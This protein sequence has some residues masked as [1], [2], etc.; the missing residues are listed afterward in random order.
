MALSVEATGWLLLAGGVAGVLGTAGGITSLVSYPALLAVG[1][2]ALPANVSNLV[3][4]VACWP[5]AALSSRRELIGH[6]RWL[7]RALPVAAI[8]AA[9]GAAALL[10]TPP[11][12]FARVVPV[13]VLAGSVALLAQPRL[14]R[15]SGQHGRETGP[16]LL[17]TLGGVSVYGGYFGAG[18]GVMLL[19]A[20]AVLLDPRLPRA[21]AVKNMLVGA[22]AVA[23]AVVLVL[24][25]PVDW[26]AVVPLAIG[27]FVGS[28]LGPVVAR[29]V[30]E[31]VVRWGVA[32]L[33]L[34]LAVQ[35]WL[36]PG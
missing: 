36:H 33:G 22:S 11:G 18:S 17:A 3:A 10:F 15:V 14:A 35:L 27:L 8:A 28:T 29:R 16:L 2:P 1:V 34:V 30:P 19:V 4:V 5:G 6:T 23:S 26:E 25:G 31:Q 20:V 7:W 32:V 13:L 21:N 24:A 12:A 9:A